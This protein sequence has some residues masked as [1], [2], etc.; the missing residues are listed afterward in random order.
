MVCG[1]SMKVGD[2]VF[3]KRT[4]R[5]GIILFVDDEDPHC[6]GVFY[7]DLGFWDLGW[8]EDLEAI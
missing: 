1:G 6:F 8:S 4:Q 2:L 3:E 5:Y 7:S